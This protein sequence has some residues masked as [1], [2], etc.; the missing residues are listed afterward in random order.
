MIE[1]IN[2]SKSFGASGL[3]PVSFTQHDGELLCIAGESGCG[4]TTML[5]I[6]S[7]MLKPDTGT[8]LVN[9]TDIGTISEHEKTALRAHTIGYMMQGNVLLPDFTVLQNIDMPARFAGK[10]PTP[11]QGKQL[12]ERLHI[13]HLLGAYPSS[14][15]GGEYRRVM[16]A[17]ILLL[18][19]PIIAADEPTSNLDSGSAA[20]VRDLLLEANQSGKSILIATHDPILLRDAPACL[21]LSAEA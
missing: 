15:S 8:V 9:G 12:A 3:Q 16:L 17:R 4:K 6:I 10:N 1:G 7:G 13:D 21:T 19:P 5:N 20:I 2:L 11:E 14:L 18:D